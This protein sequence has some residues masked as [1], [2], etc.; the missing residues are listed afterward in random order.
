MDANLADRIT[1]ANTEALRRLTTAA[2]VLVAVRRAG[3]VIPELARGVLLHAGPP[4]APESL[5]GPMRGA[6]IGA[7]RYERWADGASDAEGRLQSG[8]IE[9]RCT[10]DHGVVGP[11][12]GIVSP[13]MPLL[14]V[15]DTTHGTVAYA[16][17]NE[18]IGTVLRFGAN[19]DAVIERLRWLETVLAPALDRALARMGGLPLGPL[20]ARALT[21]GDE[22]HQRNVA[23]TSLLVRA[24][25]PGLVDARGAANGSAAHPAAVLRFLA[26][27]D[28]F[29]LNIA[30]AVAKAAAE[31]V[32]SV[33][34]ST[35]VSIMSRNGV[36]FGIRVSGLGDR[37]FTAPAPMP[38]GLYF[39][40]FAAADANP[41]MGDSAILETLGLGGF[42]MAAAPAVTG[43]LGLPSA[44]EA[45]AITRAMGEITLGRHTQWTIP[46]LDFEGAPVGIDVRRVVRLQ[47]A[48]I[49]NTGIAH[50]RAGVGQIGAGVVRAPLE[51]FQQALEA[52]TAEYAVDTGRR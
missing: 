51:V 27:T 23:A 32:R 48:P 5:C 3:E 33:P 20:V 52:F 29:F 24:L 21:M 19:N 41:D 45:A 9:L 35:V 17:L 1:A 7:M 13:S 15:R 38:D 25:A 26:D 50:R 10:H 46:A 6:A 47:I 22:M 18:G 30:M 11:M 31:A 39:P 2:P 36:E 40:G 16:P 34:G 14:V 43:F 49:I 37:W 4:V 28:Q 44:R 8:E 42:A 12:A